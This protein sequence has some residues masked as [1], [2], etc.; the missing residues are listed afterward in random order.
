MSVNL[1]DPIFFVK[2]FWQKILKIFLWPNA[3]PRFISALYNL[4]LFARECREPCAAHTS[5]RR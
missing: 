3:A 2:T 1:D 4:T 5:S